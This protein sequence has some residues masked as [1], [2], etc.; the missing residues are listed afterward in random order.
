RKGRVRPSC[1]RVD[2]R[3][4]KAHQDYHGLEIVSLR[5]K[6]PPGG[7]N[8]HQGGENSAGPPQP[9]ESRQHE[10]S[11]G[12][13]PSRKLAPASSQDLDHAA[14]PWEPHQNAATKAPHT[15]RTG[16]EAPRKSLG[17]LQAQTSQ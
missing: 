7:E 10:P 3:A 11:D 14:M 15:P 6:Y 2:N 17:V 8:D 1:K 9:W 12:P 16:S 5:I 13:P 4:K